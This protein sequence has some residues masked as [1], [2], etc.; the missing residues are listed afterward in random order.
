M[1]RITRRF[2]GDVMA[3]SRFHA[4]AAAFAATL[5]LAS[6]AALAQAVTGTFGGPTSGTG[7][8]FSASFSCF[9]TPTCTGIYNG[10][11]KISECPNTRIY[12]S[13][14]TITGL[15]LSHPGPI[16]GIISIAGANSHA[17]P[18]SPGS[19]C[20]YTAPDATVFALPFTG[21][22]ANGSATFTITATNDTGQPFTLTGQLTANVAS[23]PP[24][25]PMTV[26]GN[27]G[28]ATTDAEATI[29][30]RPQDAGT[31]QNVYVFTHA[32]ATLVSGIPGTKAAGPVPPVGAAHDD[33]VVCV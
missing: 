15:D 4:R 27:V 29:Q 8:S 3:H 24:V 6:P 5:F 2:R 22:W 28:A 7:D 1:C 31:P 18:H 20:P 26:T 14:I 21:T 25:F 16:S 10:A 17:G 13:T 12:T 11:D 19:D 32:P 30:A 23:S 33:A 9:G